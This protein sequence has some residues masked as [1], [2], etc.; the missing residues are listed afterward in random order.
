MRFGKNRFVRVFVK[1]YTTN[2]RKKGVSGVGG[3]EKEPSTVTLVKRLR[4]DD[5]EFY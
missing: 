5:D 2:N 3:E 4:M 1:K